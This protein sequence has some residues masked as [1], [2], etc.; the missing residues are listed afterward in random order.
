MIKD[1][2]YDYDNNFTAKKASFILLL[3]L[4]L[5]LYVDTIGIQHTWKIDN[6]RYVTK[7]NLSD[8]IRKQYI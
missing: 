6:S 3:W 4:L 5:L 7:L 1:N 8:S 2:V